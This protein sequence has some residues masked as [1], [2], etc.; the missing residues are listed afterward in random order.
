ML[1]KLHARK[2][3]QLLIALFTGIAFG[4]FLQKSGVARYSVI[5]GQLRL[6]DHT[7]VKMMLS[8][9]ITG[10][11]GVHALKALGYAKL[12][13]KSGS[14]GSLIPGGILFG[15][16]FALLGYCPGT[17]PAAAGQGSMDAALAGIPGM[18]AGAWLFALVYPHLNRKV[19]GWK[20]FGSRTIPE[21]LHLSPAVVVPVAV[22]ILAGVL[23]LI[24][25][26]GL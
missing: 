22:I 13:P 3:L 1:E 24:E 16:G 9:V 21:C 7:V 20:D 25:S 2:K 18:L 10:M 15:A 5:V 14:L 12:H 6:Q 11:A 8:A 17:L 19:L 4:F 23:V 26:I